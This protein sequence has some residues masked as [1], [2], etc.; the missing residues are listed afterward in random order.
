MRV[1]PTCIGEERYS[2]MVVECDQVIRLF[3]HTYILGLW[4]EL[5]AKALYSIILNKVSLVLS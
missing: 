2:L 5:S 4:T 1:E 3:H